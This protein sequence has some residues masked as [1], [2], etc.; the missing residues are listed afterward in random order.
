MD[1]HLIDNELN[2]IPKDTIRE[3]MSWWERK[4]LLFNLIIVGI[5]LLVLIPN[6]IAGSLY[7]AVDL[8]ILIRSAIYLIF[9][10]CCYCAGWGTQLL[11]YYYFNFQNDSNALDYVLYT[12]GTLFTGLFT[13]FGFLEYLRFR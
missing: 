4:R 7:I 6:L 1:D 2:E 13:Y 10:N 12:I 11:R 9:I 3:I 8:G 5:A